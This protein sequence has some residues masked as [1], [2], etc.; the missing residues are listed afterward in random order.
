MPFMWW[1]SPD[2]LASFFK[3]LTFTSLGC[4]LFF[5][6]ALFLVN[7]RIGQL[8]SSVIAKQA[9]RV[10]SQSS[11]IAEQS[12]QIRNQTDKITFLDTETNR[13][14]KIAQ[15]LQVKAQ[16]AER[17][18]SDIY[19]FQGNRRQQIGGRRIV[20][21]GGPL[22][23]SFQRMSQQRAEARWD[24]LRD[25]ANEQVRKTP[26]WLTSYLFLGIA[27]ANLGH[28]DEAHA[29]LKYLVHAAGDDPAYSMAPGVLSE[30]ELSIA[31][32]DTKK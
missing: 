26:N 15:D 30:V 25:E 21:Q 5:G 23:E 11:K 9:G 20:T 27:L 22:P 6:I 29:T 17:G 19:D 16:N 1:D 18:I 12:S 3:L 32:R 24:A 8:Q 13:L 28:L 14:Q 4:G 7:D 31:D 10:E 2:R